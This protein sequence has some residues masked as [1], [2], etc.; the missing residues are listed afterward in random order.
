MSKKDKKKQKPGPNPDKLK[1]DDE[2]WEDA[3]KTA[4]QK[5]K[6]K[7]GWPKK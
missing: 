6:P 3:A 7:E 1:I 2:N 5:K 4:I